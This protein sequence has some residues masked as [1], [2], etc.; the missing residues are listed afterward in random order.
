[1]S[2]VHHVL[3]T[4]F[5]LQSG[6]RE[7]KIRLS[8]GWLERRFMLFERFCFPSVLAQTR[9]DFFWLVYFDMATPKAYKERV[10]R[11]Q[12]EMPG[13]SPVWVPSGGKT[14]VV[15][16]VLALASNLN[17]HILTTRI[18]N[19]DGLHRDFVSMLRQS[20]EPYCQER[21]SHVFNFKQGYIHAHK[22]LYL[23]QDKSNP[24]VSLLENSESPKTVW[25]AQHVNIDDL[26]K[27][28]Q[29]D[30]APMWLQVVHGTNVRNRI[31]GTRVGSVDL[32]GFSLSDASSLN[33]NTLSVFL[34]NATLGVCRQLFEH[35]VKAVKSIF[36]I[37]RRNIKA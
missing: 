1:M 6:G 30:V 37:F 11:Y 2:R 8:E 22:K 20:A 12:K 7:R 34:E 5:N 13:F 32:S 14:N 26:G 15:K 27:M 36:R 9:K 16:D 10:A 31:K 18:D 23:H 29:I 21:A 25:G 19:D 28:H 33:Q 35:F 17:T 24:F 3:L 4:R